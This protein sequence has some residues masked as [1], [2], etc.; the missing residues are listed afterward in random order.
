MNHNHLKDQEIKMEYGGFMNSMKTILFT[1]SMIV[2][3]QACAME[4]PPVPPAQAHAEMQVKAAPVKPLVPIK[5]FPPDIQRYLFELCMESNLYDT[6][7]IILGLAGTNKRN[8]SYINENLIAILESIFYREKALGLHELLKDKKVSLP[9]MQSRRIRSWIRNAQH[10]IN[11]HP[12]DNGNALFLPMRDGNMKKFQQSLSS[13]NSSLN[14]INR[15]YGVTLLA[16]ASF[17]GSPE[18]AAVLLKAGANPNLKMTSSCMTALMFACSSGY[19][20][21]VK[22]LLE[23][24]SDPDSKDSVGR[25]ARSYALERADHKDLRKKIVG[26]LDAASLE[27]RK[28]LGLEP[29]T[30]L[31]CA[32]L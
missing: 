3:A 10:S 24:G 32:I 14:Q 8:R 5:I 20:D 12:I 9:N 17:L 1:I 29:T 6:A 26:L 31:G 4:A 21:L 25:I 28:K 7:K 15:E 30:A 18:P 23:Q 2:S 11:Q 22:I 16:Y 19:I 27:K 13:R